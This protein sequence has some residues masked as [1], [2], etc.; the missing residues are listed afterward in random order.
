MG[1]ADHPG[2]LWPTQLQAPGKGTQPSWEA[3][4]FGSALGGR[5]GILSKEIGDCPWAL[6]SHRRSTHG[7]IARCPPPHLACVAWKLRHA[8]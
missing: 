2:A 6:R 8:R 3:G 1:S 5:E 4:L 7:R